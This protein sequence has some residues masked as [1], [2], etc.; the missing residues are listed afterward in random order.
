MSDIHSDIHGKWHEA[1]SA[2]QLDAILRV[3]NSRFTLI[4]EGDS[5]IFGELDALSVSDR[6]GNIERKLSLNDGSVFATRDNGAV[7]SLL[8]KKNSFNGVLHKLESH[9]GWVAIALVVTIITS[10]AFLKWGIPWTSTKLANALPHKTNELIA[11]HTLDFLDDY[12]FER[13]SD[14]SLTRAAEIRNHFKTKL[15]PLDENNKEIEYKLHFRKW[16]MGDVAIPNALALP[17]G[18]IILTDKFVE[19]SQSQD[20]ID[21]VLLHEMGHIVYRHTLKMVIEGTLLTTAVMI[22]TGD[23]S[24]LADMGLGLGTLLVSSNYSRGHES[25]A[26]IYAF[27]KMLQANIDPQAFSDIMNRMT[28]YME[29]SL[30]ETAHQQGDHKAQSET[31]EQYDSQIQKK[32]SESILDYLSSHPNT[33]KRVAQ[34]KHYSQCFEQKILDCPPLIEE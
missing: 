19:L 13:D 9:Y 23:S 11:S 3:E 17:S 15:V 14:V 1:G 25:E 30:S 7:D 29:E 22:A 5:K 21:S 10:G 6:L 33:S 4:I 18:D 16:E 12:F 24:G 20:E 26:D 27:K 34:A 31:K 32:H 8:S 28:D 2:A